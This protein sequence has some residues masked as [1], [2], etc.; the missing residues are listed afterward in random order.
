MDGED[1]PVVRLYLPQ[2]SWLRLCPGMGL[3]QG[4]ALVLGW[5]GGEEDCKA[6]GKAKKPEMPLRGGW[7][8]VQGTP[9]LEGRAGGVGASRSGVGC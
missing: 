6:P 9:Q 2:G 3:L 7:S 4:L 1:A 5:G 8:G